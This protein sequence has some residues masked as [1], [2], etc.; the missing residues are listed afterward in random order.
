LEKEEGAP[1]AGFAAVF[2]LVVEGAP[3]L[4]VRPLS[5]ANVEAAP[6]AG[7]AEPLF[8]FDVEGEKGFGCPF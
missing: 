4:G 7:D 3:N 1:N 2:G 6:N 5:G 8:S